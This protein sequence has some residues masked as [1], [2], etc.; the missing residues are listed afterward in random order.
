[1]W[2][3]IPPSALLTHNLLCFD[4]VM[5]FPWNLNT[6]FSKNIGHTL[7]SFIWN[8]M[9]DTRTALFCS[10]DLHETYTHTETWAKDYWAISWDMKSFNTSNKKVN[11]LLSTFYNPVVERETHSGDCSKCNSNTHPWLVSYCCRRKGFTLGAFSR[12]W[13]A[14]MRGEKKKKY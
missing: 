4:L 11:T 13:K 14:E 9:R 6:P 10:M 1:M 2:Q 7:V 12:T 3:A 8:L 5:V